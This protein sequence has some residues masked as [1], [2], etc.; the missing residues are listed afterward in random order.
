M[1]AD[2]ITYWIGKPGHTIYLVFKDEATGHAV[3]SQV[4]LRSYETVLPSLQKMQRKDFI[5]LV[6]L[7]PALKSW[8]ITVDTGHGHIYGYS[9]TM[10]EAAAKA[11]Q[12]KQEWDDEQRRLTSDPAY[13]LEKLLK[14]RDWYA[15]YSD[16]FH[17]W[18]A[19]QCE[20]LLLRELLAKVPEDVAKMLWTQYAP[21][22]VMFPTEAT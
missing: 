9:D 3:T 20:D 22:E 16:D 2:T 10:E 5:G 13:A 17:A 15:H 7:P 6:S 19:G 11:I 4:D 21:S 12:M 1:R 8:S 14:N 18:S